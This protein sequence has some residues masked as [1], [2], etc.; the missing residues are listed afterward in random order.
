[1]ATQ[2]THEEVER[3]FGDFAVQVNVLLTSEFDGVAVPS[4]TR[5]IRSGVNIS[6]GCDY[7]MWVNGV[8][9]SLAQAGTAEQ[10]RKTFYATLSNAIDHYYAI[11]E[12]KNWGSGGCIHHGRKSLIMWGGK[13]LNSLNQG[14][15]QSAAAAMAAFANGV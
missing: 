13:I 15:N 11:S 10:K 12:D 3:S 8:L 9:L 14:A 7:G 1:G 2:Y 4:T 5:S 6:Y